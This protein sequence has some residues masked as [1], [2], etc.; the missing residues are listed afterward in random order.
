ML[1]II[2]T[3]NAMHAIAVRKE[4]SAICADISRLHRAWM[5][6]PDSGETDKHAIRYIPKD[7]QKNADRTKK[8]RDTSSSFCRH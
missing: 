5:C 4:A 6:R 8:N 2:S 7:A 3:V 1:R